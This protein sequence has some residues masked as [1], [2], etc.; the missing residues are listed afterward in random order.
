[1]CLLRQDMQQI[2]CK[3]VIA[4]IIEPKHRVKI[5]QAL[6]ARINFAVFDIGIFKTDGRYF[7][8]ACVLGE[9]IGEMGNRLGINDAA[10]ADNTRG[11]VTRG[12]DKANAGFGLCWNVF[13]P[14]KSSRHAI[15]RHR[16]MLALVKV[17]HSARA[18]VKHFYPP[19][20]PPKAFKTKNIS[21]LTGY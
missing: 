13:S 11:W 20:E 8:N 10:A 6:R 14:P 4:D 17:Q 16:Y 1:M 21:R 19:W 7:A 9:Q 18:I 12:N 5:R 2:P 15:W 3:G